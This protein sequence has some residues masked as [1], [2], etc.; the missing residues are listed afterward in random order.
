[1]TLIAM[2]GPALIAGL[3]GYI[4]VSL[5]GIVFITLYSLRMMYLYLGLF[6]KPQ[7]KI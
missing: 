4:E 5:A 2:V 6:L 7:Q 3:I 1:M